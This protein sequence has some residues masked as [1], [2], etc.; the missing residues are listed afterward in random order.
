MYDT[1]SG[2]TLSEFAYKSKRL[3]SVVLGCR[4]E[5][6]YDNLLGLALQSWGRYYF[7]RL[8][9]LV[10]VPPDGVLLPGRSQDPITTLQIR[11]ERLIMPIQD[12]DFKI[13][14]L[15]LKDSGYDLSR[16]HCIP[17]AYYD[18]RTR[19][20]KSN[21]TIDG[22]QAAFIFHGQAKPAFAVVLGMDGFPHS[23][24]GS[25]IILGEEES[26]VET[27]SLIKEGWTAKT[28]NMTE[29]QLLQYLINPDGS[30]A[31]KALHRSGWS[32]AEWELNEQTTVK[33]SVEKRD[34]YQGPIWFWVFYSI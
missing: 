10:L 4:V 16:V 19:V 33:I 11:P 13:G 34:S 8:D 15:Q 25:C 17:S 24:W 20:L 1:F 23:G 2:L 26:K 32:N 6:D 14:R 5:H 29:E 12:Q 30:K 27:G 3:I 21:K 7:G 9:E 22:A 18:E 31:A 28:G